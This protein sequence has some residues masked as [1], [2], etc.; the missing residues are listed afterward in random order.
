MTFNAT[1]T[2]SDILKKGIWLYLLLL[3]FEGALRKWV[4]PGLS[5]PLLIVRDPVAVAVLA[6]AIYHKAM[7]WNGYL[8][9]IV[10][11]GLIA[12]PASLLFGHG[13]PYVTLYGARYLLIH[14]PF[15]FLIGDCFD[16]SDV[17]KFGRFILWLTP[18]MTLLIVWQFYSPQSAWVNRGVGGDESGSGFSGAMGYFRPSG[19][20]SFTSGTTTYFSLA[21]AYVVYFW[22]SKTNVNR[23]LLIA[24][25]VGVVMAIPISISR[26]YFFQFIITIAF[27]VFVSLTSPRAMLSVA[28]A[29]V[30][31][32]VAFVGLQQLAFF[33]T[34]LTVFEA[35]YTGANKTEG[36]LKGVL[37]DRFLGESY[38]GLAD[39]AEKPIWGYGLGTGTAL[40][41]KL[42]ANDRTIPVVSQEGEWN[43]MIHEIGPILGLLTVAVRLTL[44]FSLLF[45]S[46]RVIRM[47]NILPWILM[48][49]GFLQITV[50]YWAQP[51]LLGFSIVMGGLVWASFNQ[52]E[53]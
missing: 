29:L 47:G 37:I 50:A 21:A 45:N 49:F 26:A 44:G 14:F 36:G 32:A 31:M 23:L 8:L 35:R 43:R 17:E 19:V 20:F 38:E 2:V 46:W 33:K 4:L 30:L 51:N 10:L 9:I 24:A 52:K 13:N 53:Y 18:L 42:L 3:I 12:I 16:K 22:L 5:E 27:G 25:S 11:A 6:F 7:N 39:A 34:S 15:L 41:W 28:V 40:G 1:F 48:S